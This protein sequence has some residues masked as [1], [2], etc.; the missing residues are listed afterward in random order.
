MVLYGHIFYCFN[1]LVMDFTSIIF[2]TYY[3]QRTTKDLE[4]LA[5]K[6]KYYYVSGKP[7]SYYDTLSYNNNAC[8]EIIEDNTSIYSSNGKEEDVFM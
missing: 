7:S 5:Y 3:E 6:T 1:S 8:I 2:D 4:T